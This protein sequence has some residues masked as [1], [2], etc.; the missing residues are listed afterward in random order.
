MA[1]ALAVLPSAIQI[2]GQQIKAGLEAETGNVLAEHPG[3]AS[4]PIG[5]ITKA[6]GLKPPT[7]TLGPP[8]STTLA[9]PT[10]TTLA[11]QP[12][13]VPAAS[14]EPDAR[15]SS[16]A[17]AEAPR[18]SDAAA[19][20]A[21]AAALV[22]AEAK[23]AEATPVTPV[24]QTPAPAPTEAPPEPMPVTP[25]P[26]T[27]APAPT[28]LPAPLPTEAPAP[29]PTPLPTEATTPL[30]APQVQPAS[31]PTPAPTTEVK[32]TESGGGG[33]DEKDEKSK[34][35]PGGST[36]KWYD[37][38]LKSPPSPASTT[39][40]PK[41][42]SAGDQ[43][44]STDD[45][46]GSFESAADGEGGRR[47]LGEKEEADEQVRRNLLEID[48]PDSLDGEDVEYDTFTVTI[49]QPME[50][51]LTRELL[52]TFHRR[53]AFRGIEDGRED[54]H[55]PVEI[56]SFHLVDPPT[57]EE[58]DELAARRSRTTLNAA[59]LLGAFELSDLEPIG[60]ASRGP[61]P[62]PPSPALARGRWQELGGL[63]H[64]VIGTV[65][66]MATVGSAIFLVAVAAERRGYVAVRRSEPGCF[67][68]A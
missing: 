14:P 63:L 55:G 1:Y 52:E 18:E 28:P 41:S 40:S 24:P 64:A 57:E 5:K 60:E 47:R 45:A 59:A 58:L 32:A 29:E 10:S 46:G 49:V 43:W 48:G 23:A 65:V 67:I 16:S 21:A 4:S 11:P 31:V 30:P 7:T 37:T 15:S 68:G 36:P 3:L 26:Q 34:V 2:S 13:E 17:D 66:G 22:E 12:V 56:E 25:V 39:A 50:Y 62:S 44:Y 61:L 53:D 8:T 33:G 51:E 19:A 20:A 9:P 6:M 42:T 35:T 38:F 54:V 27:P